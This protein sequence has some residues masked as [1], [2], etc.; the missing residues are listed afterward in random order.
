MKKSKAVGIAVLLPCLAYAVVV[1][2]TEQFFWDTSL[3]SRRLELGSALGRS[4]VLRRFPKRTIPRQRGACPVCGVYNRGA[5][6]VDLNVLNF[7]R[8][9]WGGVRHDQP[10][11]ASLDLQLFQELPRIDPTA[12]D[13]AVFKE[14]LQ[15]IVSLR[16]RGGASDF[17]PIP[18]RRKDTVKSG[19]TT[20]SLIIRE[21]SVSRLAEASQPCPGRAVIDSRSEDK[22]VN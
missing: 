18:Q 19:I 16:R 11:Y 6:R 17:L 13:I 4:A 12:G 21:A 14:I 10:L 2:L 7:E 8:F 1:A 22:T 15:A 9:K 5:E 20:A 3:S